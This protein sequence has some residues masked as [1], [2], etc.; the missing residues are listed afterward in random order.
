MD[1]MFYCHC[2]NREIPNKYNKGKKHIAKQQKG[3]LKNSRTDSFANLCLFKKQPS[4]ENELKGLKC[5]KKQL[6]RNQ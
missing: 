5:L 4:A 3:Q 1:E 6:Q 2:T